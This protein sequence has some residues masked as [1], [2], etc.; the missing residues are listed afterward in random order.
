VTTLAELSAKADHLANRIGD[1]GGASLGIIK[2]ADQNVTSST[3]LV[4]D[5]D[6]VLPVEANSAY[7]FDCWL[8]F[9]AAASG[10]FKWT[11]SVPSLAK[12]LYQALHNEGGTIGLNNS[13]TSYSNGNTVSAAGGGAVVQAITMHGNLLTDVTA[14]SL[15]LRWAQNT[16]NATMTN[17]RARSH[18]YLQKI[19]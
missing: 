16:V 5:L 1:L 2:P 17:L 8:E 6:L 10:D 15:Q 7:I 12:L 9:D 3:T 4:N 19:S 13:A 11:W 18:L 14:G